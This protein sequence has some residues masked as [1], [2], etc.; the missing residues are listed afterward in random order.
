MAFIFLSLSLWVLFSVFGEQIIEM[1]SNMCWLDELHNN[2]KNEELLTLW[3]Q[4]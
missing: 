1:H 3:F 4:W 2:E